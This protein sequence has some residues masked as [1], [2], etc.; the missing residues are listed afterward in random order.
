MINFPSSY[1]PKWC[2]P[3]FT[4]NYITLFT[5]IINGR[6]YPHQQV[7]AAKKLSAPLVGADKKLSAPLVG[8][9]KKLSAPTLLYTYIGYTAWVSKAW[10]TKSRPKEPPRRSLGPCTSSFEFFSTHYF[11]FSIL[12]TCAAYKGCIV[13]LRSLLQQKVESKEE[14]ASVLV[15]EQGILDIVGQGALLIL[16]SGH[17][18]RRWLST[19]ACLSLTCSSAPS[20][21][22][23]CVWSS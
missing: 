11:R 1:L 3:G 7:G 19:R 17:S 16:Q 13:K 4:I 15:L 22:L 14:G 20:L 9:D 6:P 8:A 23:T 21:D 5:L 18:K 10:R 12:D 2:H